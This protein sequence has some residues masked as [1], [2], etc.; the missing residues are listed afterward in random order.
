MALTKDERTW[1]ESHF[2]KVNDRLTEVL[3]DIA[4]LKVKCSIWGLIGGSIPVAIMLCGYLVT[5]W[6]GN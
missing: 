2:S 6:I 1:V 3:V 4:T 5:K